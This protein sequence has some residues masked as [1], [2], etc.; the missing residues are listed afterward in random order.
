MLP[1]IN[2]APAQAEISGQDARHICKVLRLKAG[3]AVSLTNGNGKDFSAI[4]LHSAPDRIELNVLSMTDTLTESPVKIFLCS[5][6]LKDKKMDMVIKHV[7]QLGITQWIPFYCERSVPTHNKKRL[8]SRMQRWQTI[9]AESVKQCRRSR[10]PD[11]MTPVGFDRMLAQAS[12]AEAK[13]AF[14]ENSA[15]KSTALTAVKSPKS[16]A[17][18]IGP[19][20]GFTRDEIDTAQKAGFLAFLL[21]PRILR[22]ETASICACTLIQ[23]RFGDL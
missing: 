13:I 15:E 12:H 8:Q 23:H 21:G 7:T 4:I 11:I 3:D 17:V 5:A 20:G 10:I 16:I 22:A 14:W 6:M 9:A 19:E 18:L 1:H 2:N